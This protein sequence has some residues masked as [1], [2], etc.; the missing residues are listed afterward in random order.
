MGNAAGLWN[1][2]VEGAVWRDRGEMT[3]VVVWLEIDGEG[4]SWAL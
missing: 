3:G 4:R 1:S 2:G